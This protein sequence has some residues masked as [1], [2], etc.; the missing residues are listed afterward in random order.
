[1]I[2]LDNELSFIA[3]CAD[4]VNPKHVGKA[5]INSTT[6]Y[7]A[8]IF[9]TS[10]GIADAHKTLSGYSRQY[11]MNVLMSNYCGQ[12]HGDLIREDKVHFGI[13]MGNK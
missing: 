3:I 1:M 5:N 11:R 6:L 8:S 7:I 9:F 10:N 4:I 13:I 12:N 2:N